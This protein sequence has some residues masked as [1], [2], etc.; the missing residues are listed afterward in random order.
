MMDYQ[1][2]Q[3]ELKL[4]RCY[5]SLMNAFEG[6]LVLLTE[7]SHVLDIKPEYLKHFIREIMEERYK[8]ESL[9]DELDFNFSE[10]SSRGGD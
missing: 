9:F 6:V 8:C 2:Y 4:T 10:D 5:C 3:L 7:Y 1:V